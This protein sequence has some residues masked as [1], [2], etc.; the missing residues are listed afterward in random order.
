[1]TELLKNEKTEDEMASLKKVTAAVYVCQLL[2][3]VFA[4]LPLFVG[5]LINLF[6]RGDV[7]GTW[8]E[9]H[10]DWQIRTVLLTLLGAGI[11]ALTYMIKLGF[12]FMA[13]T[14]I[15]LVY[16]IVIGWRAL[17]AGLPMEKTA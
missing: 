8:L 7:T 16:R 6:K 4:G 11:A 5:A 12:I 3:I 17:S 9:S 2:T 1:M 13:I 10:F 15:M 14:F